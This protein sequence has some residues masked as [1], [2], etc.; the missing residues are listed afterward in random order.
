MFYLWA[1]PRSPEWDQNDFE[2]GDIDQYG[3][4]R[5]DMGSADKGQKSLREAI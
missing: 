5:N 2:Q 4:E 1:R 3:A